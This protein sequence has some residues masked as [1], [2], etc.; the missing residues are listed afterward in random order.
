MLTHE[1][2]HFDIS[3]LAAEKF[4]RDLRK[5]QLTRENAGQKIQQ[6]YEA[7]S[8]WMNDMQH[9]YDRQTRNGIS[10]HD[11]EIWVD[12]ISVFNICDQRLITST[13]IFNSWRTAFTVAP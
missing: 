9:E 13:G 4:I 6:A 2:K 3:Y 11:Q 8:K 7:S 1:Q 12:K 5:A 10:R